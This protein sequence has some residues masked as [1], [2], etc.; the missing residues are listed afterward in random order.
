MTL[1]DADNEASRTDAS[2][3]VAAVNERD[4]LRQAL[5]PFALAAADLED[6]TRDSSEIWELPAAMSITAGDLRRA[7]SAL[8]RIDAILKGDGK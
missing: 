5:A 6:E 4:A 1:N 3:I 8:A 2:L 7:A